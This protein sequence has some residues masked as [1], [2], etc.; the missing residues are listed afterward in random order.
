M[1]DTVTPLCVPP[2]AIRNA[3]LLVMPPLECGSPPGMNWL[4]RSG[5]PND[6]GFAR[7]RMMPMADPSPIV[8]LPSTSDANTSA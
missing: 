4:I 7:L 3:A 8:Q 5:S 6:G 1:P 2:M